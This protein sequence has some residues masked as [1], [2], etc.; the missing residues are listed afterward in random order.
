[1][2]EEASG[3]SNSPGSAE[4]KSCSEFQAFGALSSLLCILCPPCPSPGS[5]SFPCC[6]DCFFSGAQVGM[7]ALQRSSVLVW[8]K[9]WR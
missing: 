3:P 7:Q 9:C 4:S 6:C 5:F 2:E 8:N 1:M